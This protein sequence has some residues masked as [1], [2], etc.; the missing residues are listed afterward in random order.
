MGKDRVFRGD[1]TTRQVYEEGAKQIALLVVNGINCKYALFSGHC[2]PYPVYSLL[3]VNLTLSL[4]ASIFAYGQ[5]SSGK[6]YTMNG[7]TEQTVADIF[8]YIHKV[9][10]LPRI[11]DIQALA[12][13]SIF[14]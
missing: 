12:V 2:F 10:N 7:I 13:I 3:T 8:D 14:S 5:T 1:C 4:L 11:A 6:T 9:Q